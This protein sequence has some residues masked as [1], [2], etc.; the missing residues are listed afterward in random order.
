LCRLLIEAA[1]IRPIWRQDCPYRAHWQWREFPVSPP[2][3]PRERKIDGRA[4]GMGAEAVIRRGIGTVVDVRRGDGPS[5]L[6][7]PHATDR[8]LIGRSPEIGSCRRARHRKT[9]AALKNDVSLA[10]GT[11]VSCRKRN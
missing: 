10:T 3:K 6:Q 2:P 8:C 5:L 1:S 4:N 7:T 11:G 9:Y